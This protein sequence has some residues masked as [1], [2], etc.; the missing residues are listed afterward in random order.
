MLPRFSVKKPLTVI[1]AVILVIVLGFISFSKM[2]TDLLPEMDLPYVVVMTTYPGASPEKVELSVTKPLES[3]LSTVSGIENVTS[4]SS[5]NSSMVIFEFSS[6]TNMDTAVIELSNKIDLVKG[7]LADGVSAPM[8]MKINPDLLPV[9]VASADIDG[10]SVEEA[11]Q[12]VRDTVLPA[13]QRVSGV[14]S[15]DAMGLVE[16]QLRVTLNQEKVDRLNDKILAAVDEGLV[17]AQ[18]QLKDGEQQLAQGKA[19]Y[20][21]T[22]SEKTQELVKGGLALADAKQAITLGLTALEQAGTELATKRE[23][24]TALQKALDGLESDAQ[25][26]AQGLAALKEQLPAMQQQ[27]ADGAQS[28]GDFL[29]ALPPQLTALREP[30]EK[31]QGSLDAAAKALDGLSG[32]LADQQDP[33]AALAAIRTQIT[34]A[35]RSCEAAAAA[36]PAQKTELL[37][38]R[39]NL[40]AQQQQLETGKLTLTRE[41]AKTAAQLDSTEKELKKAREEF[42]TARDAALK[43]ADIA[44]LVS[45]KTISAMLAAENFSMP[46]GTIHEE[47]ASYT[48]KVGDAFAS[49]DEVKTLVLMDIE[50]GDIG[51]V[52][53]SDIADIA[54]TD[55]T[56]DLYAKI[57]GNDGILL[58]FQ[59]QSA[60]STAE[61]SAGIRE[62]MARLEGE[63][64]GLHLT[65]LNDQ[66]VYIDIVI[67]TVLQN[68]LMGGALAILIL[69]FFLRS[70]KPTFLVAVSIPISL[71]LAVVAMYFTGV[72]LNII[73]LAGLALG[74]GMLVDNSIVVI[75]NTYRL[76]ARGLSAVAAAV[77]GARQVSGAIAASTLTTIC[78]FLPIVF[79]E[80]LSRQLFTDMGLTIAYSLLASLLIALT[81]VPA[82]S[83]KILRGKTA[84]PQP[85]FDRF[86]AFYGRVLDTA[87]RHKAL[88]LLLVCVLLGL[89]I[90]GV[91]RIGTALMPKS[92]SSELMVTLETDQETTRDETR[93]VSD[94]VLERIGAIEDVQTVGALQNS[95]SA[96]S[97]SLYVVLKENRRRTSMEIS[98]LITDSAKDLP[99]QLSASST[100]DMAAMGGTGLQVDIE[101]DDL[102]TLQTIARDIAGM[103]EGLEGTQDVSDGM[104]Q[105]AKETRIVVDKNKAM[106]YGLTVAQIYQEVAG[107]LQTET[108]ATTLTIDNLD[109]PVIIA[110]DAAKALTRD[111]LKKH[112]LTATVNG[113]EKT[114]SL[115]D[116]ATIT[117]ADGLSSIRHD[118]MTRTLSVTAAISQGHNIGLVSRELDKKLA[119]YD[120]PEGYSIAIT[121]E[122]ENINNTLR[123]LVLMVLLAVVFIYMI[124]VAQFQSFLS[125]FIVMFTIPLAFTGG[126]LALWAFGYEISTVAM[127]GLLVLA[128]IVVNNG[129]VFVDTANQ[130]RVAGMERRQ[131][132]VETGKRR[133]RPILMTALTTVLGLL[134]MALGIGTGADMFQ[135]MAVTIIFG[136]TYATVL[137]L[138]IVPILYDIFRRRAIRVVRDEDMGD[139]LAGLTD[140]ADLPDLPAPAAD[141]PP[142]S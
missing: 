56:D 115:G 139:D 75:E 34:E 54:E 110:Q 46:A 63:N 138:F 86:T 30:L 91:T 126:L 82:L 128:G 28:L 141:P 10:K 87:L 72:N 100:N 67:G 106:A 14:A 108:T 11:S 136:L 1:V 4:V 135:P 114:V 107:A 132:L 43:K 130:L 80:G 81:L 6:G 131:A 2:R 79:T 95:R 16:K 58:T 18:Q 105:V 20:E 142:Q 57:N 51:A 49:L 39:T 52:R 48:V 19:A 23:Q 29:A 26:L 124:M 125:P 96:N 74:V 44:G 90:F 13:L 50:A 24:L 119:D 21:K 133:L 97:V 15:V 76:R 73:S 104:E 102:D 111:T 68:L 69:F 25:K 42:E 140:D 33:V 12:A 77:Q 113:V 88:P 36:L 38:Q 92:D 45:Q 94:Q 120:T 41:L 123:D 89:S 99:C 37:K 8:L 9:M 7:Q 93:A 117:E 85:L 71:L 129:I 53:L 134:T 101:G 66:G 112:T 32:A 62:A 84:K 3:S 127:L 65:A 78:V 83:T 60:A 121:G 47:G 61:V 31:L 5:E 122:N 40:D 17:K 22:S 55:N 103:M 70:I 64:A 35:I 137:T 27:L 109:Y 98:Q 116:I 59:K 118:N